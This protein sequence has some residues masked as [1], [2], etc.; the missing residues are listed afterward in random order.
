MKRG[1]GG[2]SVAGVGV[3]RTEYC[4]E[5]FGVLVYCRMSIVLCDEKSYELGRVEIVGVL[6]A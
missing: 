6:Q 2:G 5:E 3:L 4:D 1:I